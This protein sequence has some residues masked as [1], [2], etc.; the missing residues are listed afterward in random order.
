MVTVPKQPGQPLPSFDA[1]M[2]HKQALW[3]KYKWAPGVFARTA[4]V[5]PAHH[6]R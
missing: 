3:S 1:L 2:S 4:D 6:G 5:H